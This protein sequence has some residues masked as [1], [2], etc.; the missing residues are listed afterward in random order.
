MQSVKG[1][2]I[3]EDAFRHE[4]LFYSGTADFVSKCSEFIVESV[5]SGE[6]IL[7]AVVQDKVD[8][9]RD[10]LNGHAEQVMFTDMAQLGRN[11]ARIIPA[12]KE[13]LAEHTPPGGRVR[14]IGEPIWAGR[15]PD[16]LVES[17]HHESLLNLALSGSPAWIVCPYDTESLEPS[18]IEEAMRSHPLLSDGEQV[19]DSGG[20]RGLHEIAR[21]L[22]GPLPAP[23]A[24]VVKTLQVRAGQLGVIRRSVRDIAF[25]FGLDAERASDLV[26]AVNELATNTLRHGG[27]LGSLKVWTKGPSLICEVNDA[28]FID[29][30]LVGRRRPGAAQE[31]GMGLWLVN[32]LCDLVQIRTSRE[33]TAIRV[34]V[35]KE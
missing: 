34:H 5:D 28:G 13:F 15:S 12:W 23:D 8:L 25:G 26:L 29:E 11:P 32:Q 18:V 35:S 4:A 30:P 19:V 33:G 27:G 6:P 14:G 3:S 7:V 21:P 9:L 17:Q 16:E 20:Y 1:G 22:Q 24:P 10:S 31:G 2:S